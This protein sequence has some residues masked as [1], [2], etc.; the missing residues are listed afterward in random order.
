M[1]TAQQ[2][3]ITLTTIVDFSGMALLAEE[4]KSG[5]AQKAT[6]EAVLTVLAH[7]LQTDKPAE[8]AIMCTPM[9]GT[10]ARLLRRY[11]APVLKAH[12]DDILDT[13]TFIDAV[14]ASHVGAGVIFINF[15]SLRKP[16]AVGP[17]YV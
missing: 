6:R 13:K 15:C 1:T 5:L 7:S 8:I 12:F 14:D 10:T 9:H 4:L 3:P 2:A 17:K 16:G 11:L